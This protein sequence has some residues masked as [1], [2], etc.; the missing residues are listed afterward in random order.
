MMVLLSVQLVTGTAALAHGEDKPGPNGGE[1]RMPGAFHTEVKGKS[2]EF[3]VFLLDIDFKNPTI[4]NSSVEARVIQMT[5]PS[6]EVDLACRKSKSSRPPKFVCVSEAY[7]P[8]AGDFLVIKAKRGTAIGAEARYKLPLLVAKSQGQSGS[9]SGV[10]ESHS[11]SHD[12][13]HGK[14]HSS[15]HSSEH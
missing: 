5:L 15:E 9:K 2:R 3:E 6:K 10:D 7:Q 13:H 1:I 14:G 12:S 8:V 4:T 11:S